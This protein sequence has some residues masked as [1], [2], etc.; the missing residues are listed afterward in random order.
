M[1]SRGDP[2]K[3]DFCANDLYMPGM[4]D[5]IADND[6]S[7]YAIAAEAKS[8]ALLFCFGKAVGAKKGCAI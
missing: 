7:V 1:A 3:V 4:S 5:G 8:Q 6:E 2:R